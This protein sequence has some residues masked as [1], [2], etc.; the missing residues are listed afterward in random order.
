MSTEPLH[1]ISLGA[2]VQSSTMALMA[3]AG[4]ITPMPTA[5]IFADTQDEPASVYKWLDWL[6]K[7]LPF[8]V[9]RVT[10]GSLSG[11]SLRVRNHQNKLGHKWSKSLIPAHIKNPD[12]SKG[13][14]GRACTA[15]YKIGPILKKVR[16]LAKIRRN[17]KSV[18]VIQWIGI[19]LEEAHRMNPSRN[20][21]A[22]HRWPLI[23]KE[24]R[25]WDCL[26]WMDKMGLPTPPR[27]A[28]IYCPFHGDHEWRRLKEEEPADFAKAVAF[29]QKL[30]A[31]KRV[32]DNMQ[33]IPFLHA[34]L[35]PLDQVD[36]ETDI[37]KG[38]FVLPG[39]GNEC[40]GMCGV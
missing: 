24:M 10:K 7:Q 9:Y 4:E 5:A 30:Q 21:W 2:G 17:E 38:Q 11:E 6:E 39:Y 27:S 28:C 3:A 8:P 22:S 1:I 16:E 34:S 40:K 37:E 23:E 35:R 18:R 19:S 32:T 31:I 36:F 33:G 29:E 15:D 20:K 14:M 13:F 12:G 25:R 26:R